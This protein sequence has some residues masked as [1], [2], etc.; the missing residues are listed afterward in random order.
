MSEPTTEQNC[1]SKPDCGAAHGSDEAAYA[2]S[3]TPRT[4]KRLQEI[5]RANYDREKHGY[6]GDTADMTSLARE[7]EREN[8]A[9]REGCSKIAAALGNGSA[10]SPKASV[11]FL[12]NALAN[13]V[14]LYCEDLRAQVWRATKNPNGESSDRESGMQRVKDV[15]D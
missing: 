14:K 2:P 13:E 5:W 15:T 11:D 10:I 6:I 12:T 4:N 1:E 8:T 7:L 3:D 9:L